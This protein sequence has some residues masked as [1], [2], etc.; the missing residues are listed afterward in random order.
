MSTPLRTGQQTSIWEKTLIGA[1][2]GVNAS[3]V[4]SSL[5]IGGISVARAA[6]CA[7]GALVGTVL[8]TKWPRTAWIILAA[9]LIAWCIVAFTPVSRRA[10]A[11]LVRS[12]PIPR[13]VDAVVVL[14]GSVTEDGMLGPEALDRLLR[15]LA[16]VRAGTSSTLVITQPRPLQD[17]SVTTAADQQR[18]I[19]L[20]STPLRVVIIDSVV[21]TRTE[22][23][24]TARQLPPSV[25][26]EIALV[27]SPLHT[28]R[29]CSVFERVGYRVVCIPSQ[30][31]DIALL[32]LATASDRLAAF[33]MA[34]WERLAIALYRHRGWL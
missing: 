22:A 27:T 4:L 34:V 10:S 26:H 12:D 5:A 7:I 11:G 19:A 24:G 9:A 23:V 6:V 25:I 20:V 16:L 2:M 17:R 13:A 14:S 21:S 28:R 15:A 32:T 33:R 1:L 30:S 8:Y 31:R 3:F 18:L 29:A